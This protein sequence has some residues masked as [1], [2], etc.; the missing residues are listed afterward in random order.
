MYREK[1]KSALH[2][3]GLFAMARHIYKR[4]S[5]SARKERTLTRLFYSNLIKP[6]DLCF[7]VG[8]N[9]GQTTEALVKC[10]ARVITIEPNP[11]CI[12]TLKWQFGRNPQVI[13]VRKAVGAEAGTAVLN[14]HGTDATA[15]IRKDWPFNNSDSEEVAVTT[16]DELISKF[17]CPK[18]CKVDVEGFETEVFNGL[19]QPIPIIYF[20][21]HR[22]ELHRARQI[23]ARLSVIG[24]I[25]SAN[26]ANVDHSVWLFD[27]WVTIDEFSERLAE[28]LP[29]IA[30]AVLKMASFS[31]G[32]REVP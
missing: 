31:E 16:L 30:N 25:T 26:L 6:G 20:E 13:L 2:R 29:P 1:L 28:K 4:L 3:I 32:D 23:L 14:F 8:A 21:I 9:V 17:G 24:K 11:L 7:D 15:S 5:P 22:E 18:L 19:S 10:G 27:D 12:P